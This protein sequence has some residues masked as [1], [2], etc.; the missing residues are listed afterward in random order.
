MSIVWIMS[1]NAV[2]SPVCL[3]HDLNPTLCFPGI[4]LQPLSSLSEGW[5]WCIV[6]L[7]LGLI[8]ELI[9]LRGHG[10]CS[11]TTEAK[12]KC[13]LISGDKTTVVDDCEFHRRCNS[14]LF[15]HTNIYKVFSVNKLCNRI[16]MKQ[17]L[18]L[19]WVLCR[20][21]WVVLFLWCFFPLQL[22]KIFPS[23]A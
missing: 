20:A 19:C 12:L 10:T 21:I 3:N 18:N 22:C 1:Q 6:E 17:L 13:T 8:L 2:I 11:C 5:L 15:F 23:N 9:L 7:L 4:F 16:V 14:D